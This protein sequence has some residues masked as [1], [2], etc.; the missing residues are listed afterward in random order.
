[1]THST[2]F[3]MRTQT[4]NEDTNNYRVGFKAI[5]EHI[6]C[7]QIHPDTDAHLC[8]IYERLPHKQKYGIFSQLSKAMGTKSQQWCV[9]HYRTVFRRALYSGKLTAA[10]KNDILEEAQKLYQNGSRI[11]DIVNDISLRYEGVHSVDIYSVVHT[12][13]VKREQLKSRITS[14]PQKETKQSQKQ[15]VALECLFSI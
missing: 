6:I 2:I 9:K 7:H 1:M 8:E 11:S 15:D 5:L 12:F 4:T 3:S 13:L 14:K 10:Q